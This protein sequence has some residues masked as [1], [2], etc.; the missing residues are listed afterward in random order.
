M[1]RCVFADSWTEHL[2]HE[3]NHHFTKQFA[4]LLD[5]KLQFLSR[6]CS[7]LFKRQDEYKALYNAMVN[8]MSGLIIF[9]LMFSLSLSILSQHLFCFRSEENAVSAAEEVTGD[10]AHP[11]KKSAR[12]MCEYDGKIVFGLRCTSFHFFCNSLSYGS[13]YKLTLHHSDST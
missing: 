13:G 7:R 11:H 5:S 1:V 6:D 3:I 4:T 2:S 10:V 12:T 8:K 9:I